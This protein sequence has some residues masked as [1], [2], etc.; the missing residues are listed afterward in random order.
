[1]NYRK[2]LNLMGNSMMRI[3]KIL[4]ILL[5]VILFIYGLILIVD[6]VEN[7]PNC[8]EADSFKEI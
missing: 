8:K 2:I 4:I 1:M 3:M 7:L 5:P 6:W